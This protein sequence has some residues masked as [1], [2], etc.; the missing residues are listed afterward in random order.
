VTAAT[1]CVSCEA[2]VAARCA[3]SVRIA[4]AAM[5]SVTTM[6]PATP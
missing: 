5:P 4:R 3:L 1:V 2:D 6:I